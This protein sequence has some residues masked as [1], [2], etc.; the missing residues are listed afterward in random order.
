MF[1]DHKPLT[2]ALCSKTDRFSPR[3]SRQLDMISQYTSDIQHIKGKDNLVA[4]ALSRPVESVINSVSTEIDGV[5][6]AKIALAQQSDEEILNIHR[7][8]L[9]FKFQSIAIPD[10]SLKLLCDVTTGTPRSLLP[11]QFR[12]PICHKLRSMSHPAVKASRS[13]LASRFVWPKMHHDIKL[14]VQQCLP[15]QQSKI[16]RHTFVP[17]GIFQ[18][19]DARFD[20]IHIDIVG[21]LPVSHGCQ[22]MCRSFYEMAQSLVNFG[23]HRRMSI[24]DLF[25]QLD[26]SFRRSFHCYNGPW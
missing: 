22:Y 1:T 7:N 5:D 18:A 6:F 11:T 20:H 2:F 10:A 12:K 16:H 15:C 14:W 9:V 26:L 13:L 23:N 17:I 25:Q 21:S 8:L 24:K 3:P 19:P 4:D